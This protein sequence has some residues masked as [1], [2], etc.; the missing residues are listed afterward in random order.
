MLKVCTDLEALSYVA[1]ERFAAL[2]KQGDP[3]IIPHSKLSN[4]TPQGKPC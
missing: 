1:A 2:D 3:K 4:F